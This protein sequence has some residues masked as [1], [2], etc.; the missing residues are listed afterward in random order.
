MKKK[1]PSHKA[2]L[3]HDP[4][5]DSLEDV[6]P[7][8]HTESFLKTYRRQVIAGGL[9]CLFLFAWWLFR[10]GA[11]A[12]VI[13]VERGSAVAAVY[14]TVNVVPVSTTLVR[15]QNQGVIARI[16]VK[17]G[18]FVKQG[19]VLAEITDSGVSLGV[20]E[21]SHNLETQKKKLEIGPA[22]KATVIAKRDQVTRL[23]KLY[24]EGNISKIEYDRQL[25]EL[26]TLE[27][28]MRTELLA[29]QTAVTEAEQLLTRAKAMSG[30]GTITAPQDGVVLDFYSQLG[31]V[32]TARQQLFSIA[33]REVQL[34]AQVNEED[35]GGLKVGMPATVRLYS[36]PNTDFK[37][38]LKE[39][40][41]KGENMS[42]TVILTLDK[43][44]ENLLT[45]MTGELNIL[46]G[47]R[48]DTLVIPTRCLRNKSR[49]LVVQSGR[50]REK[51]I[52]IGFRSIEK[53][54]VLEG[55]QQ[56]DL[57]VVNNIDD[58]H[59]NQRVRVH[60]LSGDEW[61]D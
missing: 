28:Q 12:D 29:L 60:K 33:S 2:L 31:E 37:A 27:N 47:K 18:D 26:K 24:Q 48:D 4:T 21:A 19:Q 57:I 22:S 8:I 50:I 44:P 39:V 23:L 14:G 9:V 36:F 61:K 40:L 54:E 15:T 7:D 6:T 55:L 25:S 1:R 13:E 17:E 20:E 45:G 56:G 51:K 46:V 53:S 49:V 42:Y 5:G 38:T 52:K 10:P 30:Q 16:D 58:F 11:V 3:T 43:P 32:V 34:R 41:P 59:H 35:V